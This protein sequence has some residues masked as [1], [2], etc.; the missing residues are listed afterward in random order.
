[1]DGGYTSESNKR[2]PVM[3]NPYAILTRK[4]GAIALGLLPWAASL[5][6]LYILER[7]HLWSP[8]APFR[9]FVSALIIAAGMASSFFL[10][11]WLK[12]R[13]R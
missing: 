6:L 2:V 9:A 1:M 13:D 4:L 11:T 8:D 7:E 5:L 10:Y 12:R 3:S